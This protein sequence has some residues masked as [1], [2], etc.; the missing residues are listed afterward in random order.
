MVYNENK[1]NFR[2]INDQF[3]YKDG[4]YYHS[5]IY[6]A[7]EEENAN[8]ARDYMQEHLRQALD[9]MEIER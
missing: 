7:M 9:R 3:G 4:I 2:Q 5:L 8:A 6:K 1:K